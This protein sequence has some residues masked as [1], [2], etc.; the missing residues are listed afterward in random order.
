MNTQAKVVR[1]DKPVIGITLGDINGIGPEVVIKTL[2]D[3]RLLEMMTPVIYG[4]TKV[5]SYYRKMYEID[6]L[7]YTQ[8][9][10]FDFLNQKKINVINCWQD[11]F[12]IKTG[13][14][15]PEGGK[16]A[17]LALEKAVEDLLQDQIDALV[18][19]PIN[20]HNIQSENFRYA[21][22]TE[23]ITEKL[24]AKESLMMMVAKNLRVG[25][26]TGH[27]PLKDISSKLSPA[28]LKA[29][30]SIFLDSLKQ[31]F[32]ILKPRLAVL[33]L[34]PHAGELGLLGD[35]EEKV[36][37]PTIEEFKNKGHLVV[38]P[39]PA[40]GFFGTMQQN[41]FDGVLAMYH[42]QGLI[43]FKTIA[44]E[45]GVNYTAGLSKIRTSPD[46]G[47]AYNI[48][49]KDQANPQSIR[50]AIYLACDIARQRISRLSYAES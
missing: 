29:K 44:F 7:Q 22:H 5:L 21:G 31:D 23:Y 30:I 8:I 11:T 38:G 10:G 28:L 15:T 9:K 49:G 14:V 27:V 34:N 2:R 39:F 45:D 6:D 18:T 50:E 17:F 32:G 46:H 42:D 41:K 37:A 35:E 13:S 16:S 43:P 25:V 24:G 19:A 4:S 12:E 1:S 36:I 47:T 26:A 40:D 20:K 48:A 33:A 3:A